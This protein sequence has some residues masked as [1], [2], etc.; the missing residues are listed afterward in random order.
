MC[1]CV[2]VCVCV[3]L[4]WRSHH[5]DGGVWGFTVRSSRLERRGFSSTLER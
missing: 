1:V 4:R 3:N 2:C 5:Y